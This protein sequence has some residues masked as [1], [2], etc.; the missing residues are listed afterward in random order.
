[1]SRYKFSDSDFIDAVKSSFSIRD[2]LKKLGHAPHGGSYKTFHLRVR[3]LNLDTSHFTGQGHLRGKRHCWSNKIKLEHLLITNSSVS[4]STKHKQRLINEKLIENFCVKCGIKDLWNNEPI[5]LHL[6]HINGDHFDHRIDNLRL[7]CPNCHSQTKTYCS[8]NNLLREPK[9][10]KSEFVPQEKKKCTEC[11]SRIRDIRYSSC[12]K[13]YIKNIDKLRTYKTPT[14]INW[15]TIEELKTKLE[16]MSYL[17]LGK[18]LG[19]SDNAIRKHI[20]KN[21]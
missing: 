11:G 16:T 12:K 14:K 8:K 18:E 20:K 2:S 13:C 15:P 4:L 6:D 9:I 3:K 19:I 7:L 10:R 5:V 17:Q 1:M 21:T